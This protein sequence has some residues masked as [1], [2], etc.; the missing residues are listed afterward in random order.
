[1]DRIALGQPRSFRPGGGG[2]ATSMLPAI[3]KVGLL[4]LA[5]GG[6]GGRRRLCCGFLFCG[7]FSSPLCRK[8]ASLR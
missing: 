5:R 1:M 3:G 8:S 6:G 7:A 2:G 4:A